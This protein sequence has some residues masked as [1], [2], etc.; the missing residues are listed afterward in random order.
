M[1]SSSNKKE[2]YESLRGS[3]PPREPGVPPP[4]EKRGW[5]VI[6]S[7]LTG[8]IRGRPQHPDSPEPA[9]A[10]S[11]TAV[12][13]NAPLP[14]NAAPLESIDESTILEIEHEIQRLPKVGE[15]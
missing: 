8:W 2:E 5:G 14:S 4:Q 11:L 6:G 3:S 10:S 12:D 9:P 13:E 7:A 1:S 15:N